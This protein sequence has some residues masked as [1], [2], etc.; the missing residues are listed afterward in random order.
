MSFFLLLLPH[1]LAAAAT[2][3]FLSPQLSLL[4]MIRRNGKKFPI[5]LDGEWQKGICS[6]CDATLAAAV[7]VAKTT[8]TTMLLVLCLLKIY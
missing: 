1:S 2:A 8:T 3:K 7:C 5:S 6:R 4:L